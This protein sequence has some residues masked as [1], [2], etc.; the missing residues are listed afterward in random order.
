MNNRE[1]FETWLD[2]CD[3][4]GL[5]AEVALDVLRAYFNRYP[6]ECLEDMDIAMSDWDI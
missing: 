6:E 3:E 2:L 1:I 4:Q 5:S